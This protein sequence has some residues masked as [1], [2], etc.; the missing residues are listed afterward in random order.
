[1]LDDL[2]AQRQTDARPLVDIAG[3]Q[4]LK[5][6]ENPLLM[7]FVEADA[8]VFDRDAAGFLGRRTLS[9]ALLAGATKRP[10]TRIKGLSSGRRNF[11]ALPIKFCNNCRICKGSA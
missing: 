2:P 5:D 6:A 3:V 8:V 7:F 4:S 11:K 10:S 1:M 9:T